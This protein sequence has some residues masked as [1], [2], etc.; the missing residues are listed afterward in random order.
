MSAICLCSL[1]ALAAL[2]EMIWLYS[3][4]RGVGIEGHSP[5]VLIP[6]ALLDCQIA[7]VPNELPAILATLEIQFGL[8]S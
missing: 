2:R 6:L 5:T 1:C 4:V 3:Q 8:W 7:G